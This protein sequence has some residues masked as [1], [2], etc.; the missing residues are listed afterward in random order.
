MSFQSSAT[1]L[2]KVFH[3]LLLVILNQF[4]KWYVL[5]PF[6]DIFLVGDFLSK[7]SYGVGRYGDS[8]EIACNLRIAAQPD[9]GQ[10]GVIAFPSDT[11]SLTPSLRVM[12]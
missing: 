1:I 11:D 12:A 7:D 2:R 9:R 8:L 6:S 5:H 10:V 3:L 4:I